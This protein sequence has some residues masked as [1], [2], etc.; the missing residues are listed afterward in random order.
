MSDDRSHMSFAIV[1]FL[2]RDEVGIV[3]VSWI[4]GNTCKWPNLPTRIVDKKVK[5]G[6]P[7]GEDSDDIEIQVKGLFMSWGEAR[8]MLPAAEYHSD[9]NES[10]LPPKRIRRP[11]MVY[12]DDDD[13]YDFPPVPQNF[14]AKGK[15]PV[16][17]PLDTSAHSRKIAAKQTLTD[18][19]S[20]SPCHT[21]SRER[22][23]G[24][25]LDSRCP[26]SQSSFTDESTPL[27][28]SSQRAVSTEV[29]STR[30]VQLDGQ[31]DVQSCRSSVSADVT[32]SHKDLQ[33]STA[34]AGASLV[35]VPRAPQPM[36]SYEFQHQVL[37]N[38]NILRLAI[39][40]QGELLSSLMPLQNSLSEAPKLLENPLSSVKEFET[41]EG[42]LTP[43]R[44]K[45]LVP[46][47]LTKNLSKLHGTK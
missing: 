29:E 19:C 3:P 5:R 40:Q 43:D 2:D 44:E 25:Q 21:N 39:Q 17:V 38:F 14:A 30:S 10:R 33:D 31:D 35:Q 9:L 12:S 41:F 20:N 42:Q 45:Q 22:Q 8:K 47:T 26:S 23:S 46:F 37:K 27:R 11:R 18:G 1:H 15:L 4:H 36:P 28:F 13:D 7:P 16:A 6:L 24:K 32:G 34:G